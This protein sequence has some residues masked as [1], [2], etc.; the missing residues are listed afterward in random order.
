MQWIRTQAWIGKAWSMMVRV[1]NTDTGVDAEMQRCRHR[2]RCEKTMGLLKQLENLRRT[3]NNPTGWWCGSELGKCWQWWEKTR[4]K[5]WKTLSSPRW[6]G[7]RCPELVTGSR[8]QVEVAVMATDVHGNLPMMGHMTR[9]AAYLVTVVSKELRLE[10]WLSFAQH[11]RSQESIYHQAGN[12][13]LKHKGAIFVIP[14]LG[15]ADTTSRFLYALFLGFDA[16]FCMKRKKVS[17]NEWD[18]SLSEGWGCFVE[19]GPYKEHLRKHWDQKQDVCKH[20]LLSI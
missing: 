12:S 18:P 10:S 5:V 13:H 11:A 8:K 17:S 6:N 9:R 20:C 16:N 4:V 15:C 2:S 7:P 19:E 3:K 14:L 1:Q